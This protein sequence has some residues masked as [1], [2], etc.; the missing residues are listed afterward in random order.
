MT[1][2]QEDFECLVR[3][4]CEPNHA[5]FIIAADKFCA[6]CSTVHEVLQAMAQVVALSATNV[7]DPDG[8]VGEIA[9]N[10]IKCLAF[11]KQMSGQLEGGFNVQTH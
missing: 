8:F 9:N 5:D 10:A 7:N 6:S 1:R 2:T 11:A 4:T 3:A